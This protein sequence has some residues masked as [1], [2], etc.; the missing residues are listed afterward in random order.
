MVRVDRHWKVSPS[1]PVFLVVP[2]GTAGPIARS[3]QLNALDRVTELN[4]LVLDRGGL[5]AAR[6]ATSV[7]LIR[8]L[9]AQGYRRRSCPRWCSS[10]HSM[11]RSVAMR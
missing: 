10:K 2:R 8:A 4:G 3:S 11:V 1:A 9:K 6:P 5:F 7:S